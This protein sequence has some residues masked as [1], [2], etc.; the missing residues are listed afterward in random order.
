MKDKEFLQNKV[1]Y[2]KDVLK[3]L[4]K[5]A[6][7]ESELI[8]QRH[9]RSQDGKLYTDISNEISDEINELTDT[10]Y[11]HLVAHPEKLGKPAYQK[12]LLRHF[13]EFVQERKKFRGRIKDLP[14]KYRAAMV[15]TEIATQ[16]VYHGGFEVPFEEK[17]DQFVRKLSREIAA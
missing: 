10:I 5:R 16:S 17:V 15:S 2:V 3:V 9:N 6:I 13:P 11:E 4:E 8:F 1:E 7:D 12:V 14:F